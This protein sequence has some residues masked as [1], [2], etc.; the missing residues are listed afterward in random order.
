MQRINRNIVWGLK[1]LTATI[2]FVTV[3]LVLTRDAWSQTFPL[4]IPQAEEGVYCF[5]KQSATDVANEPPDSDVVLLAHMKSGECI[6][7]K[8]MVVYTQRVYTN[9]KTNV[10]EGKI[11]TTTVFN[12]TT[13]TAIGERDI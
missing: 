3:Y 4:N 6:V 12:P 5:T 13:Y 11:G 8:A 10:Y 7:A 2:A 9:G 1:I